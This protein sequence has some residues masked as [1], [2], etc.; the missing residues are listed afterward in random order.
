MISGKSRTCDLRRRA[1]CMLWRSEITGPAIRQRKPGQV[2]C[3]SKCRVGNRVRAT[4]APL[5]ANAGGGRASAAG[6]GLFYPALARTRQCGGVRAGACVDLCDFCAG[7]VGAFASSARVQPG[8]NVGDRNHDARGEQTLPRGWC[9]DGGIVGVL[10]RGDERSRIS[11][12]GAG[13]GAGAGG[14]HRARALPARA[15]KEYCAGGAKRC[16]RARAA[17]GGDDSQ[18]PVACM[19]ARR[20]GAIL[21]TGADSTCGGVS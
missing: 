13:G 21:R 10:G 4:R 5:V 15:E 16:R 6:V 8:G 11:S 19:D 20:D 3:A 18:R 14:G 1:A 2:G 12:R 9:G 17:A 7:K